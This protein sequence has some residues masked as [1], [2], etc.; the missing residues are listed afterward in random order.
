MAAQDGW[1]RGVTNRNTITSVTIV[2][3]HTP[4][5]SEDEV[6]NADV[7]N[8]GSIRCY[9]TGTSLVISGN[10]TTGN[11]YANADSR[12]MFS[13]SSIDIENLEDSMASFVLLESITGLETLDISNV[14]TMYAM[15]YGCKALTEL[16]LSS[17][18]TNN[19]T[20]G[21]FMFTNCN[22][23][24]RVTLGANFTLHNRLPTPSSIYISGA[25]GK[26]YSVTTGTGY[27]PIS[28]PSGVAATYVA[29]QPS[30]KSLSLAEF[31][32]EEPEETPE[33][34][35]EEVPE[36]AAAETPEES[37]EEAP[38][39]TP[40]EAPAETPEETPEEVPAE[41]PAEAGEEL[42]A[43]TPA[44]APEETPEEVPTE[45]PAEIPAETPAETPAEAPEGETKETSSEDAEEPDEKKHQNEA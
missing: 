17:W 40:E 42:P 7:E 6:W 18:D 13:H 1:Y 30:A 33:T 36:E 2:D 8:S 21:Y 27:F 37:P 44:E 15:F 25:N 38:E 43:E 19:V 28:L 9:L 29:V 31:I 5:G 45:A 10:G 11:I 3:D 4:T 12:R 24:A 34:V 41:A 20:N 32:A 14:T 26:W 35:P 39:E 22:H 16:D 23:L